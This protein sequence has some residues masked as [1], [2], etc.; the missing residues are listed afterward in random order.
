MSKIERE[1]IINRLKKCIE[2]HSD[3]YKRH[4]NL[5]VNIQNKILYLENGAEFKC[6]DANWVISYV[7]GQ[8]RSCQILDVE[9]EK[10]LS[11]VKDCI[12]TVEDAKESYK[13]SYNEFLKGRGG[14]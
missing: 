10:K 12:F 1:E 4:P 5:L 11:D 9:R 14:K 6:K 7:A 3:F 8:I 2:T 13:E